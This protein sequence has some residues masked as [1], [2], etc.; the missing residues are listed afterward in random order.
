MSR[1]LSRRLLMILIVNL[2][3]LRTPAVRGDGENVRDVRHCDVSTAFAEALYL[4][5]ERVMVVA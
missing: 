5:F 1:D 3:P 2:V 4:F